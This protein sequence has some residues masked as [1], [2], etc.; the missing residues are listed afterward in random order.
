MGIISAGPGAPIVVSSG[1]GGKFHAY[2]N[3]ST[4]PLFVIA[5]NPQRQQLSFHNPGTVDIMVAP[6]IV[7]NYNT[8]AQETLVPTTATLGGCYRVY[9]NGGQLTITGE[10]AVAWQAFSVSGANNPLTVMDSN[11]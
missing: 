9:A 10:N 8:G 7:I 6:L 3:I 5:A 1:S 4:A 2:N 11:W